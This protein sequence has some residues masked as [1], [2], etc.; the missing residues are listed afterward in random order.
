MS[1]SNIAVKLSGVTKR[2]GDIIAI[3]YLSL[4]VK[5]ERSSASWGRTVL[6]SPRLLR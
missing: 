2:Y 6:E 1:N 3:D 4:D 5:V